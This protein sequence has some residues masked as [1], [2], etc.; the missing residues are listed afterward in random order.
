MTEL[1]SITEQGRVARLLVD[2]SLYELEEVDRN[3]CFI[4]HKILE[5]KI[6]MIQMPFNQLKYLMMGFDPNKLN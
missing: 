1:K 6:F 2:L 3:T 4:H 5:E